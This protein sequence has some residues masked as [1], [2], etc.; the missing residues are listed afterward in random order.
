M[1]VNETALSYAT[2]SVSLRY[3]IMKAWWISCLLYRGAPWH[4]AEFMSEVEPPKKQQKTRPKSFPLIIWMPP[5]LRCTHLIYAYRAWL[6]YTLYQGKTLR[7]KSDSDL[8]L[9]N[10]S[11][12]NISSKKTPNLFV[13]LKKL[14]YLCIVS[15]I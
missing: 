12:N 3:R 5:L 7:D 2:A 8:L 10:F 13:N 6:V 14:F 15:L 1:K 4:F 9:Q 11:F